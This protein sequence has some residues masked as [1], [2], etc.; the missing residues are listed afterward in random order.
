MDR[1]RNTSKSSIQTK[2]FQFNAAGRELMKRKMLRLTPGDSE[3][4][5]VATMFPDAPA[6]ANSG[7]GFCPDARLLNGFRESRSTRNAI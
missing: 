6:T 5:N 2:R 3:S 4:N 1:C 7:E